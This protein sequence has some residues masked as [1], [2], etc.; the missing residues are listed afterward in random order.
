MNYFVLIVVAVAGIALGSYF[1]RQRNGWLADRGQ[2]E[3]ICNL[4]SQK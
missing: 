1:A 2:E 4:T 3:I